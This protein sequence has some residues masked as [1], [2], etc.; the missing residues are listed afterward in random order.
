MMMTKQEVK[1]ELKQA[2]GNPEVRARDQAETAP[3]V[4]AQDDAGSS[5]S[6]RGD[7]QP[8]LIRMSLRV[9]RKDRSCSGAADE[10]DRTIS[11]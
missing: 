11:R 10:K 5:E 4:D 1:E 7:H 8:D 9:R 3:A 6:G 2:E